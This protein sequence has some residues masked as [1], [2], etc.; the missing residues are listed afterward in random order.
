[1]RAASARVGIA[2]MCLG[3]LMFAL[4]DVMG[5]WLMASYTVGQVLLLRSLAAL[6]ILAPLVWR[7]GW[8]PTLIVSQPRLHLARVMFGTLETAAF[9][10]AV[11]T[12]PLVDVMAYYLATPL[13]V[14]AIAPFLLHE[15]LS[16][17][18]WCAVLIGFAGVML[19]LRPSAATLSGPALIALVGGLLY[20]GL[21]ISTRRLQ[22]ASALSLISLQTL[23]AF[24]FGALLLPFGFV[25]PSPRDFALLSLL[26]VVAMAA[27]VC[28][29][30]ALRYAPAAI[31]SPFQYTTIIWGALFGWLFF[32]E[33]PELPVILGSCVIVLT[34][35]YLLWRE[36]Q[37]RSQP[38]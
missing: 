15:R 4:N 33:W 37:S 13:Y 11:S 16:L 9:Y 22:G 38:A 26:G 35:L 30:Q 19:V 17:D 21:L 31:V 5:K 24:V 2:L 10:W 7:A 34:G 20:A 6:A 14:A 8:R 36:N 28:V 18:R 1:M 25:S 27:H 12:M 3:V 23:G 29:A 32:N